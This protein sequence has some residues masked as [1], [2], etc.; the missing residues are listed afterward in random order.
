MFSS[1]KVKTVLNDLNVLV[2]TADHTDGN[3]VL[4]KELQRTDRQS[5]P[6]NL[7]YPA[8]P[9]QPAIMMPEVLTPD[10][11]IEALR[12]AAQNS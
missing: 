7:I 4:K 8:D 10:N 12:K 5:L 6:V 9:S 1:D 2:V 11:V 3:E